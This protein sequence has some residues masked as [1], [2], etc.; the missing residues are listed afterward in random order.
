MAQ[1]HTSTLALMEAG[2]TIVQQGSL[3]ATSGTDTHAIV[4]STQ[5]AE[6]D[7][8]ILTEFREAVRRRGSKFYTCSHILS[9]PDFCIALLCSRGYALDQSVTP[10]ISHRAYVAAWRAI[11]TVGAIGSPGVRDWL[12]QHT[13][14]RTAA[15]YASRKGLD[16]HHDRYGSDHG[17]SESG[18]IPIVAKFQ[19]CIESG[20]VL[21]LNDTVLCGAFNSTNV[22]ITT[23]Y[24]VSEMRAHHEVRALRNSS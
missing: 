14:E 12:R 1:I 3:T 16:I 24:A 21:E 11:G 23:G 22:C 20:D 13:A 18:D 6:A 9:Y 5:P 4:W 15:G 17:R 2:Y 7:K 10:K 8:Q 19:S